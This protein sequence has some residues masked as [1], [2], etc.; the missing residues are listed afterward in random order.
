MSRIER[1]V[2]VG[3]SAA[4]KDVVAERIKLLTGAEIVSTSS[5]VRKIA[6]EQGLVNPTRGELQTLANEHREKFG[7]DIFA[8]MALSE[9]ETL[10]CPVI[11]NGVRNPSEIQVFGQNVLVVGVDAEQKIRF[12]RSLRRGRPS[13]PK[14][15]EEFLICDRREN[16]SLDGDGRGQQNLACLRRAN[17]IIRNNIDSLEGLEQAVD[18]LVDKLMQSL[19]LPREIEVRSFKDEKTPL[20]VLN[21]PHGAGKT[22]IGRIIA[23]IFQTA[24]Q[25][26]IGGILRQEVGYNA[27][28][29][30]EEFDREVMRKELLRDYD[31]RENDISSQYVVETWHTGNIAYAMLRSPDLA[32]AYLDELIKRLSRFEVSHVLLTISDSTFF[33]RA[34]EKVETRDREK[35]L[36]F[37]KT[38]V[39][40]TKDLYSKLNLVHIE[41]ENNQGSVKKTLQKLL[42]SLKKP[43]QR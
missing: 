22:T 27:L 15:Y 10:S 17:V 31:L 37:Y 18:T 33:S 28:D 30:S 34:T 43:I 36:R 7:D 42:E 23:N 32:I 11:I 38:I 2:I 3:P 1:I 4:G 14:T 9:V 39:E 26:E 5:Q 16:G 13:D 8:R 24:F 19:E 25:A 41:V 40:N 6:G 12:K 21:G 20:I 29:S 35:L